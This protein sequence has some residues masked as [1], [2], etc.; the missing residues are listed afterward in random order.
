MDKRFYIVQRGIQTGPL[1]WKDVLQLKFSP[2]TL[3]WTPGFEDWISVN[4][5]DELLSK[6]G[7]PFGGMHKIENED[8]LAL[9]NEKIF[10]NINANS[11]NVFI[12]NDIKNTFGYALASRGKR[13]LAFIF[14]WFISV[15]VYD[16]TDKMT[17]SYSSFSLFFIPLTAIISYH[18]WSANIGHKILGLKVIQAK[19]G[20]DFRSPLLGFLRELCKYFFFWFIIP[21]VWLL[22]DSKKQNLYDLIFGTLVVQQKKEDEI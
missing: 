14:N 7:L 20:E 5:K 9:Q 16:L 10:G 15:I 1:N 8:N 3:V 11:A 6:L 13:L 22:W 12:S 2:N 4:S 18:L 21:I 19:T 17:S